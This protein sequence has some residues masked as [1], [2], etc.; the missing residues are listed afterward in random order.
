MQD[1]PTHSTLQPVILIP[2]LEELGDPWPALRAR[3]EE[4]EGGGTLVVRYGLGPS[5]FRSRDVAIL[6]RLAGFEPSSPRRVAAGM[7]M[8]ARWRPREMA[9]L[10]CSVVVPCRNE[11]DNVERLV[12][13][14]PSLGTHTEL[15][16]VDG[17]S[18]DGT[19]KRIEAIMRAHDVRD[20]SLLHQ[21]GQGGK[22]EAVF[23][24]FDAARGDI[25][26]I[27]DADMAVAP[28]DLERFYAALSE[29]VADFANGTRFVYP[30]EKGAM[31]GAN[32][33]GNRAFSRFLS[34]I[35]G[36]PISDSLCGTKALFKRDWPAI[37]AARPLFGRHD[38][39]GDFDLLLGAAYAGLAIV[40][41]PVHYGSRTA[42]ESKMRPL[43]DGP[44]LAR[45]CLAGARHLK[46]R[47]QRE[48]PQP[49]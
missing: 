12:R 34:W 32:N 48:R 9:A 40:D 5:C 4:L 27:L 20:I 44:A 13:R 38:P 26:M 6:L 17:A 41:V 25:L 3:W 8:A 42:G 46:L 31:P 18:T 49:R 15:I 19:A 1:A 28:E 2:A 30:M 33:L 37:A 11:V 23:M 21:R 29:G 43:R 14:L 36:S 45:T 35:L 22:A 10:S 16:F 39:W 24:G 7:E 47:R